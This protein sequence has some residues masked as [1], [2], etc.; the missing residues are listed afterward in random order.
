MRISNNCIT[1]IK[2][3]EGCYLESYKDPVGVWTIGYGTTSADAAITGT[4]IKAGMEID[5]ETAEKWL[6]ESLERKY[7]P[8]VRKYD[9]VYKWNQNQFDALVSFAYNVGSIDQLTGNGKRSIDTISSKLLA[10]CYAGGKRFNGLYRRREAE[11]ALFDAR[12]NE[13]QKEYSMNDLQLA[14]IC[15][16]CQ[17]SSVKVWQILLEGVGYH[18]GPADGI[19]G[20]KTLEA[21]KKWQQENGL[22]ADG[23]VGIK[24]WTKMLDMRVTP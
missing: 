24:S 8:L 9:S 22:D 18:C 15:Y 23:I 6:V 10:Y 12:P 3:F 4:Q 17:C 11:K 16:D 7:A 1:L 5:Q 19:F 20:S 13:P 21:T 14:T 2:E